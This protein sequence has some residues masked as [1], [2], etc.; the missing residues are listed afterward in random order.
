V[1]ENRALRKEAIEESGTFLS[2]VS[3][4]FLLHNQNQSDDQM[5]E[6]GMEKV[7]MTRVTHRLYGYTY[8]KENT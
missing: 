3:W 2:G 5:K 4:R 7:G 1:F 6:D 8:R